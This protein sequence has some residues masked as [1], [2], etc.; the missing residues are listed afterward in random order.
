MGA[1]GGGGGGGRPGGKREKRQGKREKGRREERDEEKEKGK[2][3]KKEFKEKREKGINW[4]HVDDEMHCVTASCIEHVYI[5]DRHHHSIT[6]SIQEPHPPRQ[7]F[8]T[9]HT[10]QS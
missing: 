4:G 8:F 1:G 9:L 2:G 6:A 3:E 10:L 5:E 7:S